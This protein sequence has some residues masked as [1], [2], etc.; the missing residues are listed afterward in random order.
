MLSLMSAVK[1]FFQWTCQNV[2]FGRLTNV[3]KI[4]F[5]AIYRITPSPV[6]STLAFD[7]CATEAGS[8]GLG[9]APIC[10]SQRR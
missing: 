7:A 3:L 5:N 8:N 9:N 6:L 2:G 1:R 4:V 10:N